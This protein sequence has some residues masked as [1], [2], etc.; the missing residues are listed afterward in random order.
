[1]FKKIK[2][3]LQFNEKGTVGVEFVFFNMR[4]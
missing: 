4:S 2:S 1:V 3:P